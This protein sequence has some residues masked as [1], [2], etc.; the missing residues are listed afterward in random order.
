M[1]PACIESFIF[2]V[3]LSFQQA[4][5]T[6]VG[7][8]AGAKQYQRCRQVLR[9]CIACASVSTLILS[10]V[11]YALGP[12]LLSIYITD[13]PQ[14]VAYGMMRFG[15]VAICYCICCT[16]DICTGALRGLG[17]SIVPMIVAVMGIC[18]FRLVW[19][20]TIFRIPAFHTPEI[21]YLSFPVSWFITGLCQL[22][23][24][25]MVHR[26]LVEGE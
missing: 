6:F 17:K 21:L 13:S 3:D 25:H 10:G 18:G 16:M 9:I 11:V 1:P 14:A 20:Y 26:G 22:G 5:V 12:R 24:F 2:T 15:I 8:N 7:Q 4:T 23:A 19:I